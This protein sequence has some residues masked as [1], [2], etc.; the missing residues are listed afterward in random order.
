MSHADSYASF[1]RLLSRHSPYP[2]GNTR[3]YA[4]KPSTGVCF[5]PAWLIAS[6]KKKRE[7]HNRSLCRDS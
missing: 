3:P 6:R 4:G 5:R 1:G 7:R 2:A